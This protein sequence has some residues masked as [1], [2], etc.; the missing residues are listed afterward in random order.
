MGGMVKPLAVPAALEELV[1]PHI[2]SFDYFISEG[3]E[4]VVQELRPVEVRHAV[5]TFSLCVFV[6][7]MPSCLVS[8]KRCYSWCAE[9]GKAGKYDDLERVCLRCYVMQ[10]YHAQPPSAKMHLSCLAHLVCLLGV[11]PRLTEA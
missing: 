1:R 6:S 8:I 11:Y 3:L 10:L 4:R 2:D 5:Q 9:Q 7:L